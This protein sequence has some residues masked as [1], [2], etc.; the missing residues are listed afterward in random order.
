MAMC[1]RFLY[2]FKKKNIWCSHVQITFAFN[3][4]FDCL[5]L[6]LTDFFSLSEKENTNKNPLYL[7]K[8]ICTI[9]LTCQQ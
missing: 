5:L 7:L 2:D 1:L 4:L 6:I 3:I 8:E 9:K